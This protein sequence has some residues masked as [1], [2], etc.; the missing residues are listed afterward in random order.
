MALPAISFSEE[1]KIH[2]KFQ[3]EMKYTYPLDRERAHNEYHVDTYFF[4]PKNL[5]VNRATYHRDDFYNDMQRYIRLK[6]PAYLLRVMIDGEQC[7][8]KKLARAMERLATIGGEEHRKSYHERLKMFCSI[9]KS[10]LRDEEAY[11]ETSAP[12]GDLATLAGRFLDTAADI[13]SQFRG[14]RLTLQTPSVAD[15]ERQ[16]FS[17]VDEFLSVTVNKYRYRLWTFLEQKAPGAGTAEVKASIVRAAEDEINYRR[18][19]GFISVPD[20]YGD[21]EEYVYRE[22]VLKKIMASVLFLR[23]STRRDG[24]LLENLLFGVA[25]GIAMAFA[26]GVS[27]LWK[28]LLLQ[29]FSLSFFVIWVIAYMWKDR[30]KEWLRGYF[31]ARLKR[32][33]YDYRTTVF[34]GL[35]REVGVC[36]EGFGFIGEA[37]LDP[38]IAAARNKSLLSAVE[39]GELGEDIIM[40]R[41]NVR[42]RSHDCAHIFADFPVD[43]VVDIMRFNLRHFLEKMDNPGKEIFMPDGRGGIAAV[44]GRR[45]YHVNVVVHSRM[46]GQKD[47]IRRF[48]LVLSR[49]GI[50][51]L[52]SL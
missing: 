39:N 28:S 31:Q 17:L 15:D 6:T 18:E 44:K 7:P 46:E 43:G 38:R 48:R 3:I 45:V 29:E 11:L 42:L 34:S 37:E 32:V 47:S 26:T 13:L 51:R 25:A 2:D 19:N 41:K 36:Q 23:T 9:M 22:S 24:L 12:A 35:G 4:L 52:E 21:N 1:L 33:I 49:S 27:F 8:L 40:A 14:L 20:P 5:F 10:A 30:I 50:K 16:L